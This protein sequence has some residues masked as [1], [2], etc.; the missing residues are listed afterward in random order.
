MSGLGQALNIAKT[1]LMAQRYGMDVTA[2]NIANVNTP[3]YSRQRP[4]QS[5]KRPAIY[6]GLVFGRGVDTK[7]ILRSSD[8][9][10]EN[11]LMQQKSSLSSSKEMENY[12][13]IIEGF[14]NENPETGLSAMFSKFWNLWQDIANN[15][16]G[17]SE[18]VALYEHSALI[19]EEFNT[20]NT[21]LSQMVTDLTNAIED[22]VDKI[23]KI[24][25]EIAQLNNEIVGSKTSGVANDLLDQRNKLLSE[26]SEY[27]DEKSFEQENGT[28][29]II[30]AKGCVLVN[31]LDS[32]DLTLG[33]DNQDR[34]MWKGSGGEKTDITNRIS[35]GKL[36]GWLDMRDEIL[37]KY[38]KNLDAMTKEFIWAVNQQHTQGVG[39]KTLSALTGTYAV[40]D[41]GEEL[42]TTDSG[43]DYSDKI[44]DGSF[45]LWVYDSSGSVVGESPTEITIDS[46]PGGTT[47]TS[48][49]DVINGI[50]N[51]NAT[52]TPERKLKI[53]ADSGYTFAFSSDTSHVLAALGLNTFFTGSDSGNIGINSKVTTDKDLIAAAKIDENGQFSSGDNSNAQAI[54]DV[55]YTSMDIPQWTCDRLNGDTEG[56]IN[57][58]IE[59]YYHSM[60]G[61][62]GIASSGI[63]RGREFHEAMVNKLGEIRDGISAVSLDE[64]MTNL[65]K[66]QHA[67]NAAAKL[68]SVSDEMLK[69]LLDMK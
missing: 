58:T 20:L 68:I 5:S 45:K 67:Y 33:G 24:T 54:S 12:I 21:D 35:K 43:L 46:D 48:L 42:G 11:Q 38:Q 63:S 7:E 29:T 57:T 39:S 56:S 59:D 60:V 26:L 25:K 8:Q 53:E 51:L 37:A 41:N 61:S 1:A 10:I 14:F 18:R 2:Q 6:G 4:I 55:Q 50:A 65:I 36:S 47:L 34:V 31:G 19:S 52:I 23:N 22:G 69:I 16:S 32:Y 49:K 27:I 30:T 9:F 3:G 15:P 28:F 13:K 17:S 64:E 40:S 62:V 44:S 66:F